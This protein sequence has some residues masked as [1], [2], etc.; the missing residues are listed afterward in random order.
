MNTEAEPVLAGSKLQKSQDW[1]FIEEL[2][3]LDA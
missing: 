3:T 1:K 2:E